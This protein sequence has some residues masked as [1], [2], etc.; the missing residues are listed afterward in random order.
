MPSL[1][2]FQSLWA[3]ELRR[4]DAFE[5]CLEDKVR[6][7]ADAGF[8]GV[9]LDLGYHDQQAVQAA[10]PF[11]EECGLDLIFNVFVSDSQGFRAATDFVN[12]L[13]PTTRF[14]SIIGQLQPWHVDEVAMQTRKWLEIGNAA[15]LPTFVESH[16][17]CMTND[18]HFTLQLLE[19]VSELMM[20]ADLSHVLVNQEWYLPLPD[21]A[22]ALITRL[23]RRSESFQGRI[24]TR[25]QIQVPLAF[26]QHQEWFHLSRQWWREGF[27]HW[28]ERHGRSSDDACVFLCELGPPPYAITGADGYELS[29]RWQEALIIK[30][31]VETLWTSL[32]EGAKSA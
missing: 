22:N 2:V 23:L 6:K 4:P 26:P 1:D 31:T 25:E 14:L 21:H 20:V 29:D 32:T 24:A 19:Q 10:M 9:C 17:N 3:M 30:E 5:Y 13:R 28:I 18:L 7:I 12:S 27:S 8:R 16:R 15:G 11:V